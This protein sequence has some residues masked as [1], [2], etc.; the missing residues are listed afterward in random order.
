MQL[1]LCNEPIAM[2]ARI[3]QREKIYF[4][5][6]NKLAALYGPYVKKKQIRMEE[7]GVRRSGSMFLHVIMAESLSMQYFAF[8]RTRERDAKLC[9]ECVCT[10]CVESKA[11][12]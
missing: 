5:C 12:L 1:H 6:K 2:I 7:K 11:G 10:V 3:R 9:L 4:N 8:F